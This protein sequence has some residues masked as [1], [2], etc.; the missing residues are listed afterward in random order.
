MSVKGVRILKARVFKMLKLQVL[1]SWE[2]GFQNQTPIFLP[3]G[4]SYGAVKKGIR[5]LVILAI[6]QINKN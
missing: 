4:I 5:Y 2:G 6:E 1:V 3:A